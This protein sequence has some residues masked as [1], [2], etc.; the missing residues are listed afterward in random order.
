MQLLLQDAG[1]MERFYTEYGCYRN[2]GDDGICGTTDDS[3]P[4]Y[5]AVS[6]P[7]IMPYSCS[8]AMDN[9]EKC[10]KVENV[11][12]VFYK[13]SLDAATGSNGSTFTL[14]ADPSGT[15]QESDGKLT[16]DNNATHGWPKNPSGNVKSWQ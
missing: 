3:N 13:I 2:R 7:P 6:P 4:E 10:F 11:G 15:P 14:T 9:N 16:L 1:F 5:P 12:K 8:P